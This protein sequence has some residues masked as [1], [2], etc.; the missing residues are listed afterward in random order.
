MEIIPLDDRP[1]EE[2]P[3]QIR[4]G[5]HTARNV[6]EGDPSRSDNFS[7]RIAY[8]DSSFGSN[9]H[10][11]NFDQWRYVVDGEADYEQSGK[12][13]AGT[14]GYFPEGAYY[15]ENAGGPRTIAIV[16]FGGPSGWGY[17]KPHQLGESFAALEKTGVFE[18]G[19]YR[20]NPGVPGKAVQDSYEALWEHKFQRDVVYPAP[21]YTTPIIMNTANYPWVP[22]E[23]TP[24]VAEK[25]LGTFTHCKIR[26]GRYKL[27]PGAELTATGRGIYLVLSGAGAVEDGKYG[28]LTTIYLENGEKAALHADTVTEVLLMGLP[29]SELILRQSEAPAAS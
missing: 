21:Q 24:G 14:L 17:F 15:A 20:R 23:G 2:R 13:P 18:K 29:D 6:A 28:D 5:H 8:V 25:A 1:N 16:Q 10:H 9:A 22:V 26:A 27:D 4:Q 3:F 12:M 7:M 19:L 11:H